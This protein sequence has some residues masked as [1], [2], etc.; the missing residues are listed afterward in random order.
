[1]HVLR[2]ALPDIDGAEIDALVAAAD[3]SP[4]RAL[5]YAGLSVA[6]LDRDLA[7]IAETGDADNRIRSRLAKA[8]AGKGAQPRYAV[9]LD[10]A[11]ALI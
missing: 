3:G 6:A 1:A 4:G 5:D 9:F 10:R 2:A 8:L 11:P 7:T